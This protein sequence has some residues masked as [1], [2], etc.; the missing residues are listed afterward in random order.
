M[1]NDLLLKKAW[2]PNLTLQI[3]YKPAVGS[4]YAVIVF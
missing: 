4:T 1:K 2:K 3:D